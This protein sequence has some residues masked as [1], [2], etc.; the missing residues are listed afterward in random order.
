VRPGTT[1]TQLPKKFTHQR[2]AR[3]Q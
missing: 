3:E 2:S 1:P